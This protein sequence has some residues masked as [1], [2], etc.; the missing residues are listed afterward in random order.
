MA[1]A[2]ADF[3]QRH[4]VPATVEPIK[5]SAPLYTSPENPFIQKFLAL[6][7]K[8]T[9]ANWFCDA[10]CFA[11]EGTPAIAI[12]PG[13]IAQAH[14]ADEYIEIAKLERGAEFFTNYLLSFENGRVEA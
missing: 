14:T 11:L 12:G 10:A 3:F 2:V 7:S 13:S 1:A 9:G 6:G 5:I 8:L 4:H